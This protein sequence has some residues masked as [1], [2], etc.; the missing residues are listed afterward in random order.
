MI[1]DIKKILL[2]A[3]F[4]EFR[5]DVS[6]GFTIYEDIDQI[7]MIECQTA[8]N[9]MS[10]RGL[11]ATYKRHELNRYKQ[12]LEK[13]NIVYGQER[14]EKYRWALVITQNKERR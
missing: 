14:I 9:F 7:I 5:E 13:A 2:N 10:P 6:F 8:S 3:G 12:A 4:V 1:E 11:I